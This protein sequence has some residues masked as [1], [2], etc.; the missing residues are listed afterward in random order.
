MSLLMRDNCSIKINKPHQERIAMSLQQYYQMT[1]VDVFFQAKLNP[2]H[3]L[4]ILA[5][6]IDW[7]GIS[8]KLAPFYKKTGRN[9]KSI[10]LMVG[11]HILKHRHNMSDE[12]VVQR[13][14]GDIY[15]MAF[16]G[17]E[18]PLTSPDWK[19]LNSSTMTVFRKRIK[20]EGVKLIEDVIRDQL[21]EK[22]QIN[23]KSQFVDTTAQEKNIDYPTDSSLLDKGRKRILK[24]LK[25]LQKLGRK[26]T[27]NR[28][29]KNVARKTILEIAKLGKD[30]KERIEKGTHKLI[31]FAR[32]VLKDVSNALKPARPRKDS[33]KQKEIEKTQ[34]Q[35]RKD[36]EIVERVIEQAEARYEGVHI[37]G[38]VYSLHE[39]QVACITK[40]KRGKKHEYGS[41]VVVSTDKNGFVVH[42]EEYDYNVGDINTFETTVEGWEEATGQIAEECAADRGFHATE[43]AP[44]IKQIK[45]LAIPT[46]GKTKHPDSKKAPFKRLQRKRA[47]QEPIIGHLK[48]DHRMNLNRYKGF[49]GDRMNVSWAVIAWNTKKWGRNMTKKRK[50][51]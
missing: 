27:I 37:N 11:S 12:E 40:G 1:F 38:K 5:E 4:L 33:K 43:Y 6:K 45:Y 29:F 41:K 9:G 35:I 18:N 20:A 22:K 2:E 50:A 21:L 46:K 42:H 8:E 10:R 3:E 26:V 51:G 39:P 48:S 15:W 47:A 36:A 44:K 24:G 23:P 16:C 14:G 19:P 13:L 30:R 34:D 28:T 32:Q 7:E 25:K 17:I 49:D 31:D